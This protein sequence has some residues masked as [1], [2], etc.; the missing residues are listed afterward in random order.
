[1]PGE[2]PYSSASV[3]VTGLAVDQQDRPILSGIAIAHVTACGYATHYADYQTRSYLARLTTGG[4]PDSGFGV[5][6][7]D[8]D[9]YHEV[10]EAPTEDRE[11]RIVYVAS[12]EGLCPRVSLGLAPEIGVLGPAATSWT[13][14]A[15][16][17]GEIG[18][19]LSVSALAALRPAQSDSGGAEPEL[20]LAVGHGRGIPIAGHALA[21]QRRPGPGLWK[22]RLDRSEAAGS[23]CRI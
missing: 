13:V 7:V 4:Q 10:K 9:P 17:N 14:P 5:D 23:V 20:G 8:T 6:G 3:R 21:P 15:G 12:T 19:E 22:G 16:G 1:V 2:F 11:E 18:S